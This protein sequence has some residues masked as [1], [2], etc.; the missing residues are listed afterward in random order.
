MILVPSTESEAMFQEDAES[1]VRLKW[2]GE[3]NHPLGVM[4]TYLCYAGALP[5]SRIKRQKERCLH[6]FF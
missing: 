6:S 5:R 2:E 1:G 4:A 3:G